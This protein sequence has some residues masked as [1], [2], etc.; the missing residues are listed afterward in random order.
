MQKTL[1]I[2]NAE[3][4]MRVTI[5]RMKGNISVG[6]KVYKL[7]S[8][9]LLDLARSSYSNTENIKNHINCTIIVKENE[10]RFH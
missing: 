1:N 7:S 4:G 5:G 2:P 6:D 3:S 8:K 10:P 9:V